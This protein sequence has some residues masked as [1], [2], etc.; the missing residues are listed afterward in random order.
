M[1]R[2]LSAIFSNTENQKVHLNHWK[3]ENDSTPKLLKIS[4][5]AH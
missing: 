5:L 2:E 1:Q 4:I 3:P